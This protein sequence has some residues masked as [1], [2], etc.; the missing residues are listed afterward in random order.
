[1]T[2]IFDIAGGV[3]SGH[4]HI[5]TL[6]ADRRLT[7]ERIVSV[8]HQTPKQ[9][10]YDQAQD[11]WVA[12]LQGEAVLTFDDGGDVHVGRGEWTF[13]PAHRKHRVAR[14]SVDPACIWLALHFR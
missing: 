9:D 13:I 6:F 7:I 12:V 1:M 11:E 10:W 4:E 14:T 2:N 8:G 3:R 5:D